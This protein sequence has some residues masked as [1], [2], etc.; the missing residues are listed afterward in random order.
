[1]LPESYQFFGDEP[2]VPVIVIH[3]LDQAVPLARALVAG[4][5]TSLEVT[6]R[7]ACGLDAIRLIAK[8]VP[9]ATVGAGTVC[10][11]AQFSAVVDAGAQF[12]V[13]PGS[14]DAL[15][16]IAVN[17]GIPTLP[18]AVTA[19]EIMR[20]LDFGFP[21]IK[22]FPAATSGGVA[23]IKAFSGPFS[24]ARFLPTGGIDPSNARDYLALPNVVAVGGSWLTPSDAVASSD[25]SRITDLAKASAEFGPEQPKQLRSALV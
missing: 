3:Q 4:G 15:L 18:G 25:W 23:A 22:F 21:I 11:A 2:V 19:S 16:N 1:M 20:V 13:T 10:N 7:T 17:S 12:V 9:E 8:E 24:H 6:L 5:V 14:T